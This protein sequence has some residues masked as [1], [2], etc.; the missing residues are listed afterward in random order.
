MTPV[1][2]HFN[3]LD[4]RASA[5]KSSA[6]VKV[7]VIGSRMPSRLIGIVGVEDYNQ[8]LEREAIRFRVPT[9]VA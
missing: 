5:S 3:R 7:V 2:F 9:S 8:P 4:V 1:L 6:D